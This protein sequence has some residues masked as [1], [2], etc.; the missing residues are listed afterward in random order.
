MRGFKQ[1]IT[2]SNFEYLQ[3]N[4]IKLSEYLLQLKDAKNEPL[5]NHRRKTFILGFVSTAKSVINLAAEL[6]NREVRPYDYFLTYK[7]S[8]DHLELF[9]CC[10]RSRGGFNNNPNVIQFKT[11]MK[12]ILLKNPIVASSKGNVLCFESESVGSLFSLKWT[13]RR[14]PV[15]EMNQHEL[16]CTDDEDI[17]YLM[18]RMFTV[19]NITIK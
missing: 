14:T 9:F 10:I 11:S 12:Q 5:V 16:A 6:L 4:A 3:S 7:V 1:P 8:Q 17:Q 13:K 19:T 2:T 18:F 15:S